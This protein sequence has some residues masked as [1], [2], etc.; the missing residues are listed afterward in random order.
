MRVCSLVVVAMLLTA[1]CDGDATAPSNTSVVP[2]AATD[3]PAASPSDPVAGRCPTGLREVGVA[4]FAAESEGFPTVAEALASWQGSDWRLRPDWQALT[5]LEPRPVPDGM[6][7]QFI[8]ET[9]SFV[10]LEVDYTRVNGGW[11]VS[12]WE[13]C[14]PPP[15][16]AGAPQSGCSDADVWTDPPATVTLV[17]TAFIEVPWE[18]W[19]CPGLGADNLADP[20]EHVVEAVGGVVEIHFDSTLV[21]EFS[22]AA[23]SD[24]ESPEAIDAPLVSEAPGR[25]T[26]TVPEG[27]DWVVRLRLATADDRVAYYAA[28]VKTGPTPLADGAAFDESVL[29]VDYQCGFGVYASDPDETVGVWVVFLDRS[30]ASAGLTPR[31]VELPH[32][33]WRVVL[34]TGRHLFGNHCSDLL[35][36][37]EPV[38]AE[39]FVAIAGSI[40]I[41]ELHV[42]DGCGSTTAVVDNLV[43]EDPDG[44]R[45]TV[46]PL[47]ITNTAWG[48]FG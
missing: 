22:V 17:G 25:L 6:S 44:K 30:A 32:E 10:Y 47:M 40:A 9:G 5:P 39:S 14:G 15:G 4:T 7:Q 23:R 42:G 3:P 48:C 46:G 37:P 21:N 41:T 19:E 43:F 8:D 24:T 27:T 18:S 33:D 1:A 38:V 35:V 20:H 28:V 34:E 29:S 45:V 13:S 16:V 12:G 36:E 26:L 31:Q 11:E 2:T